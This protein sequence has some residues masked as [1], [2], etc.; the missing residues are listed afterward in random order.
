MKGMLVGAIMAGAFS[1]ADVRRSP[2]GRW[3]T[4]ERG[5]E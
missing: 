2:A 1:P 5:P 4:E 3:R